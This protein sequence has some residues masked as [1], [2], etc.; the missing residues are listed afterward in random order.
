MLVA[1]STKLTAKLEETIVMQWQKMSDRGGREALVLIARLD[2][3][4]P[5]CG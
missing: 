1:T 3:G 4:G 5:V 2:V